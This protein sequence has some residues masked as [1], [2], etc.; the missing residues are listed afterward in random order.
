MN[1]I[2]EDDQKDAAESLKRLLSVYRDSEDLINIGAYQRGSN[3][4]IDKAIQA[5]DQINAYTRQKT[6]EKVSLQEAQQRLI[7]D[8]FGR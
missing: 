4:E 2:V 3:P 5:I 8:F 6:N 7:I 1:D